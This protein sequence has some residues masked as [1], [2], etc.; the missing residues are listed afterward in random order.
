MSCPELHNDSAGAFIQTHHL[1]RIISHSDERSGDMQANDITYL[2]I[3]LA[4]LEHVLNFIDD[5]YLDTPIAQIST[6]M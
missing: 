1:P 3:S 2:A 6:G 4:R 5:L